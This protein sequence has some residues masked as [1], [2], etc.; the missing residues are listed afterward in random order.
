MENYCLKT[1]WFK[2]KIISFVEN[3]DIE[4]ICLYVQREYIIQTIP[5]NKDDWFATDYGVLAPCLHSLS[6][7]KNVKYLMSAQKKLHYKI[8][9]RH[10]YQFL[11]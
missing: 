7:F 10:D 1:R 9:L 6:A 2:K 4:T 3:Y 5:M 11:V 8:D